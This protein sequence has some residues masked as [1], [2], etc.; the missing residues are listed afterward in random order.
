MRRRYTIRRVVPADLDLIQGIEA[1]SFGA[2]AYDRK[3]FA[4]Y[5][6]RC[7]ELFLVAA[8]GRRVFGY[9][10]TCIRGG[11][12]GTAAE[13]VSIAVDPASRQGGAASALLDSTLRRLRRRGATRLHLVVRVTNEPAQALYE[14]YGF[15]RVRVLRGYYE[16]GGDGIL[17]TRPL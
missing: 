17:M 6:A 1:A 12:R 16:D 7:G 13:L 14:K 5:F 2:E 4:A 11:R 8:R 3:L 15:R 10:I 9:M